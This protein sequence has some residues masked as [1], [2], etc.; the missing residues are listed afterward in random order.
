[1]Q[2]NETAGA[3]DG[4]GAKVWC[5]GATSGAGAGAP[6]APALATGLEGEAV[7]YVCKRN[8]NVSLD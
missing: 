4:A 6:V 5:W 1:M 3:T 2:K 8:R 7:L